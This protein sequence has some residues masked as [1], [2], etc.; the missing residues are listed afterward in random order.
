MAEDRA[1]GQER[2]EAPT[3]R[4]RQKAREEGQVPRSH[5]VSA[6]FVLLAGAFVLAGA[7]GLA[8]ARFARTTVQQCAHWIAGPP[9]E[10]ASGVSMLVQ[11]F[12]GLV[13]ALLPFLLVL[14]GVV[15]AVNLL[16][17]RGVFTWRPVMPKM[18]HLDP[19]AG[20]RRLVSPEAGFTLLKSLAKLAALALIGYAVIQRSWPEASS[21]TMASPSEIAAVLKTLL[22]RLALWVGLSFLALAV[23]DYW[24]QW[25]R[26]EKSLRMTRQEVVY[27]FR[28]TEG[29]PIVKGRIRVLARA[30]ARRRMLQKVPLADVVVV[31]PT[32]IAVAL[33]YDTAVAP[34]PIVLAM[35]QRKLA[36]RIRD[37]ANQARVPVVENRPVARALLATS[38]VG[39]PI[40]PALYAAVAEILA[41]IY[42]RRAAAAASVAVAEPGRLA[43]R[44]A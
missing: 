28:E 17:A 9:I 5:E 43:R 6:A 33:K 3:A 22:V 24:F 34:A 14:G 39:R 37:L 31:N 12:R 15:L 4:R 16:Q 11:V 18:S 23:V 32:E 13:L 36:Q 1:G 41:F 42:R 38:K 21:L 27:E 35:G 19:L 44:A 29:D 25:S 2:N 40:P 10:T 26:M 7:G 8:L 20:F 30:M